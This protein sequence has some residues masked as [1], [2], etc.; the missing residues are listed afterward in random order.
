MNLSL[1]VSRRRLAIMATTVATFTGAGLVWL[2]LNLQLGNMAVG[3]RLISGFV[4]DDQ[5]R[6]RWT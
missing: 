3:Q 6:D 1:Q 4:R 2:A 5:M